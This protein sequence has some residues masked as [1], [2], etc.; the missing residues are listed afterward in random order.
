VRVTYITYQGIFEDNT[1]AR[2]SISLC[3]Q[4]YSYFLLFTAADSKFGSD[5]HKRVLQ[6]F[7]EYW[8][9]ISWELSLKFDALTEETV[10]LEKIFSMFDL[11]V[12]LT[13]QNSN[14]ENFNLVIPGQPLVVYL[15]QKSGVDYNTEDWL[16]K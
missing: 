16:E 11:A 1:F 14:G 3:K 13:A 9:K 6:Q 2:A 15:S 4:L 8:N 12:C 5:F 7:S 10:S